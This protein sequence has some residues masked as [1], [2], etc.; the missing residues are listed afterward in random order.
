MI[1]RRVLSGFLIVGLVV[2]C[3]NMS[4]TVRVGTD[5]SG[6]VTERLT[7]SPQ[8]AQMMRKMQQMGDSTASEGGLFTIEEIRARADSTPGL[9]LES[10]ELLSGP[11]GEGYEAVYSFDNLSAVDFNPSPD[12]VLPEQSENEGDGDAPFDLLSDVDFAHEAGTPA[13][14]TITM[15][16]SGEEDVGMDTPGEGPPSDPQMQMMRQMMSDSGF[17]LA[18]T[19][20]GEIVETNASHRSGS[21]ITLMEMDFGTLAQDSAAFRKVMT[22]EQQPVSSRA[23]IDSIN[24]IPGI[25]IEPQETVTVRYK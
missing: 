15:P 20:D 25:T 1:F 16:R 19:V 12:D 2:G 22:N 13:T 7:I 17:R 4:S 10:S 23:A 6:T 21:T 24:A 9:R 14:L 8:F 3:M 5:G 11:N 18:V